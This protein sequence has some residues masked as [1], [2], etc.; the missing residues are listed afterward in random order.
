MIDIENQLAN[1]PELSEVF[2][3]QSEGLQRKVREETDVRETE[4]LRRQLRAWHGLAGQAE[5]RG[6]LA[7]AGKYR[8]LASETESM[9]RQ[10]NR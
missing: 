7:E 9:L 8:G 3:R 10:R 6:D 2:A 5:A 4:E 1:D